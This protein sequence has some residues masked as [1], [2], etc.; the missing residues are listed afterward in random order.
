LKIASAEPNDLT[1]WTEMVNN[2]KLGS[3]LAG[4]ID[5]IFDSNEAQDDSLD[6]IQ[7]DECPPKYPAMIMPGESFC[8]GK[9]LVTAKDEARYLVIVD[10]QNKIP[11]LNEEDNLAYIKLEGNDVSVIQPNLAYIP[12][13]EQGPLQDDPPVKLPENL[14]I[15]PL[16]GPDPVSMYFNFSGGEVITNPPN[17]SGAYPPNS[18]PSPY[19]LI[20]EFY[21]DN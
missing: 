20:D 9:Y 13:T 2:W 6:T 15:M 18:S 19:K 21:G 17:E 11:E 10:P 7:A 4:L 12:S 8:L 1:A 14:E 16:I 5:I 3:V